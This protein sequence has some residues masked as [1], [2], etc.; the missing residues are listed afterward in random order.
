MTTTAP[1]AP[2]LRRLAVPLYFP[3]GMATLGAGVILPVLPVYLEESGLRLSV[4]GVVTA[5]AGLGSAL[6]GVPASSLAER[7][8]TDRLLVV[9]LLGLAGT[10]AL[11]GA[12]DVAVL[13]V[14]LQ[15][16]N[17]LAFAGITQSRQLVVARS[18]QVRLRGRVNSFV[19]GLHRLTFVIGPLIGG[20]VFD[21]FGAQATFG[22]AGA[23]T[24]CGLAFSV[25]PGGRDDTP[26]AAPEHRVRVVPSIWRHRARL[27]RAGLGPLLIMAARRGR[28][29]VVPLIGDELAL[30]G[31]AIGALVAVGTAA[32]FVLFPVS[33]YVMD[34][35]GRLASMVPAFS[36]MAVGLLLLGLADTV[37]QAVVAGVIMGIGN[38]MSSGSMLTISTDM[39]P[40]DEPGPFLAGFHTMTGA[41]SFVGPLIVGWVAE[42]VGLGAAAIALAVT[43]GIGV[44][45]IVFVIGETATVPDGI[46]R[47]D[48]RTGRAARPPGPG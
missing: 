14:A 6:G 11:L 31:A 38:G 41:G 43:L 4:V 48:R 44:A 40:R 28:Y 36:L 29:V 3:W 9:A 21:R 5:A 16:V 24:A 39:A 42:A 12:T 33:G 30:S 7:R 25:L 46:R 1:L 27:A 19:G 2:E 37:T 18:T 10:T 45:W 23:L 34:R 22:L 13:L 20:V 17:G 35:W 15:M 26:L 32:D 47:S 8:G